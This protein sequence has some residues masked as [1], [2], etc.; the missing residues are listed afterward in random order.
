MNRPKYAQPIE[1]CFDWSDCPMSLAATSLGLESQRY[2]QPKIDRS[3]I[4][5]QSSKS[6]V[7]ARFLAQR[8]KYAPSKA[9]PSARTCGVCGESYRRSQKACRIAGFGNSRANYI[10]ILVPPQY[11]GYIA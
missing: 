10:A 7:H 5:F 6:G 1:E 3:T 8:P 4:R 9:I 2:R 11:S